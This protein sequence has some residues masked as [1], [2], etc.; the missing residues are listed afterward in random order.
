LLSAC[1]ALASPIIAKEG[2]N[3]DFSYQIE[4]D[5]V[6]FYFKHLF[7]FFYLLFINAILPAEINQ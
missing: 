2:I 1:I 3:F 6:L 7:Y 4:V 5:Q